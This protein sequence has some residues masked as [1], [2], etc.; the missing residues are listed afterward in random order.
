MKQVVVTDISSG[1]GYA[2]EFRVYGSVRN[3]TG[4]D[5]LQRDIPLRVL[6][7]LV[8]QFVGIKRRTQA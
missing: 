5:R 1:I 7:G 8:V 6:N 3:Q 2:R 4:A